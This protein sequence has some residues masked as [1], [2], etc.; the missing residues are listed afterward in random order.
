MPADNPLHRRKSDAGAFKFGRLVQSLKRTEQPRCVR[1]VESRA[2]VAQESRPG[3]PARAITPNSMRAVA[4]F[5]VNFQ[6]FSSRFIIAAR[7]RV[8]SHH[9]RIPGAITNSATRSGSRDVSSAASD[10]IKRAQIDLL[11]VHLDARQAGKV[12]QIL[13]QVAHAARGV[14]DALQDRVRPS[15][16][17]CPRMEF[18]QRLAEPRDPAQ[19]TAQIVRHR[20]AERL[21]LAIHLVQLVELPLQVAVQRLDLL[22]RPPA[23]LDGVLQ[24]GVLPLQQLRLL[25]Q[26]GA[27]CGAIPRR[28]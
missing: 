22:F 12:E 6:E 2:V 14:V 4:C 18:E 20:I 19:R 24:L 21:Q 9:A 5:R 27:I 25:R 1:H 23:P 8:G 7:I 10:A 28:R 11:L 15:S 26:Q 17:S 13:H 16:S 3:R